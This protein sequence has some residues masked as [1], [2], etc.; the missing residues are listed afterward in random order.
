MCESDWADFHHSP[1]WPAWSDVLQ[2]GSQLELSP[3]GDL[4]EEETGPPQG[5]VSSTD[6]SQSF[7]LL[8]DS[9]S[10]LPT[11]HAHF[12]S[13]PA[14]IYRIQLIEHLMVSG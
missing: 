3:A 4:N 10:Q 6:L 9:V 5:Q 13:I 8:L 14:L 11:G 2:P 7:S 1:E 12:I